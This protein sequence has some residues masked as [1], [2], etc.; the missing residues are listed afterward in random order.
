MVHGHPEIF[1]A[2]V[3]AVSC[4]RGVLVETASLL[5]DIHGLRPWLVHEAVLVFLRDLEDVT[6]YRFLHSEAMLLDALRVAEGPWYDA[7]TIAMRMHA[8]WGTFVREASR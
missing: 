3:A 6:G 8:E 7:L 2:I 5:D 4:S 1:A